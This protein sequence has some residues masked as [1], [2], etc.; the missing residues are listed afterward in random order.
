MKTIQA[1]IARDESGM[2]CCFD[3]KPIKLESE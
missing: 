3:N 2:L 1:W